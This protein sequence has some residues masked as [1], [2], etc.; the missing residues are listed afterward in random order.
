MA[1]F[2]W[3]L[4]GHSRI[5]SYFGTRTHPVTGKAQSFHGGIDISA[6]TGVPIYAA[7]AGTVS[8][9]R[10]AGTYGNMVL[11]NHGSGYQT[12]YAHLSKFS[13]SAGQTVA[14]GQQIGLV[15]ATGR[16][17]G[18]H[19]HFEVIVNGKVV[20]P[21][22]YVKASDT[23][24]SYTGGAV[25]AGS[26][27]SVPSTDATSQAVIHIPQTEKVYT[28]YDDDTPNKQPDLY[29]YVW[30]SIDNKEVKEITD[31]VGTPTLEDD[32]DS[33]SLKFTFSV[34][35]SYGE[36]FMPPLAIVPGDFISVTNTG[37]QETIFLGQ[38]QSMNGSYR[39][40]MSYTCLDAG[41]LLTTN[42]V[43][44]QFNNVAAKTA[45]N[46]LAN[47]V[48]IQNISCPELISSVYDIV[49]DNAATIAKNILNTV[50]AENGVPYFLR[51][52]GETLVVR[53]FGKDCIRGWYRQE[54]NLA[55][56]DILDEASAP[57]GSWSI[58]EMRNHIQ[59]Y[60]DSGDAVTILASEEDAASIQRYGRR[61]ALETFSD[62]NGVTAAAKARTV[63]AEKNQVA[64]EF[65]L[66]CYG[67]DR[68]VG[69]CRLKVDLAE[70][71]G[72]FWVE[73]VTH[74]L[75]PPH[76]MDLTLRRAD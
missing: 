62:Q 21:L 23:A 46:H 54:A 29:R 14:A 7:R 13:V 66:H 64:E 9:A 44:L 4:P 65:S 43:I 15:G 31:R 71:Q 40:S 58:E 42:D 63:L 11:I 8:Q 22:S 59:V 56:F 25:V 1:S 48:G 39:D 28:K 76:T 35:Q 72:E 45:L 60:S 68:I 74:N 70:A 38:V 75:G 47:K 6:G 2:I 10:M 36:K 49:K 5:T 24:A 55:A 73:R 16:V 3:P 17:T 57:N 30:Q 50:T 12:R 19:L 32:T 41:R 37:S 33:L 53:S 51:M 27:G 69:G 20:N 61:T 18:P 67:S 34:L 26:A 52:M